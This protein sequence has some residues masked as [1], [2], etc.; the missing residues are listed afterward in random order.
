M[1]FLLNQQASGKCT[2]GGNAKPIIGNPRVKVAG[3]SALT[4]QSLFVVTGCGVHPPCVL[5]GFPSGAARVKIMGVPALL[6][7]SQGKNLPN[8]AKTSIK[9][10]QTRVKGQ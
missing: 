10:T 1:S 6:D 8:G 4:T 7:S 9:Q 3:Q 5:A 2:H